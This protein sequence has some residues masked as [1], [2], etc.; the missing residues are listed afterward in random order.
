M[1]P[2]FADETRFEIG[3]ISGILEF[4]KSPNFEEA[5]DAGTDNMYQ[6]TVQATVSDNENPRHFATQE[7]TVIVTDL[8]EAPVFSPTTD[9]LEITEN[10][11]D[12]NKEPPVSSRVSVPAE[13]GRR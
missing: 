3:S 2:A 12:P 7:V 11:D 6:V 1:A 8:N 9:A 13:P 5:R 10:P 4:K